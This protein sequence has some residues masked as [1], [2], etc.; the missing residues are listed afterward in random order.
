MPPSSW[1]YMYESSSKLT[2]AACS[3]CM[4]SICKT[5]TMEAVCSTETSMNSY[6]T[7]RRYIPD[8]GRVRCSWIPLWEAQVQRFLTLLI[9]ALIPQFLLCIV[10][11]S[12]I[13]LFTFPLFLP[14]ILLCFQ[15]F[16]VPALSCTSVSKDSPHIQASWGEV[17]IW[18]EFLGHVTGGGPLYRKASVL[19]VISVFQTIP[20][21]LADNNRTKISRFSSQ[22]VVM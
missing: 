5:L 1:S 21:T 15:L 19:K 8:G 22:H 12:F 14:I 20:E 11:P 13:F 9:F 6:Q 17:N 7:T 2:I 18:P 10:L 4:V 3:F 16:P